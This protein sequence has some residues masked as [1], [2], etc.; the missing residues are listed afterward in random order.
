[1]FLFVVDGWMTSKRARDCL[2]FRYS[3]DTSLQRVTMWML[4][5][6][7]STAMFA[8]YVCTGVE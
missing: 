6:R 5:R 7:M 4:V 2:P 1:M 3:G 8:L